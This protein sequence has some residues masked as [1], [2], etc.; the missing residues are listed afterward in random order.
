MTKLKKP[1]HRSAFTEMMY[2]G[3]C[4]KPMVIDNKKV[5]PRRQKK[6]NTKNYKDYLANA[7]NWNAYQI[8]QD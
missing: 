6:I 2:L 5:R 4:F 7:F 8:F 3:G 1:S